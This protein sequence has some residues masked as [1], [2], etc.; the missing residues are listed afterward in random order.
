MLCTGRLRRKRGVWTMFSCPV[1]ARCVHG[2]P[3]A[4]SLQTQL[5]A[6][7]T[8][9]SMAPDRASTPVWAPAASKTAVGPDPTYTTLPPH[10]FEQEVHGCRR[11][12]ACCLRPCAIPP[13]LRRGLDEKRRPHAWVRAPSSLTPTAGLRRVSQGAASGCPNRHFGSSRF[14]AGHRGP[15]HGHCSLASLAARHGS[16]PSRD[17]AMLI[18]LPPPIPLQTFPDAL[19]GPPNPP[20]PS[21][22]LHAALQA[23]RRTVYHPERATRATVVYHTL[24]AMRRR[25]LAAG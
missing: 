8:P 24:R 2:A 11:R 4:R 9:P 5:A 16:S 22:P 1:A 13:D 19:E 6:Q 12:L 23:K 25:V 10:L 14:C 7:T 20:P 15:R 21:N 17:P 3:W 18:L